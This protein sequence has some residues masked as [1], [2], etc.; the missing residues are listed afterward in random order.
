MPTDRRTRSRRP[1]EEVV[2]DHE[3]LRE[4]VDY[5]SRTQERG[6]IPEFLAMNRAEQAARR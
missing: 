2:H 1:W 3:P 5:A 4:E 6:P